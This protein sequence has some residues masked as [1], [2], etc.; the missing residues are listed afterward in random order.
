MFEYIIK[1]LKRQPLKTIEM[2]GQGIDEL[3]AHYH[4]KHQLKIWMRE[5]E[6]EGRRI[7]VVNSEFIYDHKSD[8]LNIC[9]MTAQY[10]IFR[11]QKR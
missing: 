7:E 4:A 6:K 1:Y 2:T 11:T 8:V 5:E 3:S 10:R 9:K